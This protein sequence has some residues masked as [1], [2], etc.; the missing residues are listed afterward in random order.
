[1]DAVTTEHW[2]YLPAEIAAAISIQDITAPPKI[3]PKALVC[4]GS[5]NSVMITAES[6]GDLVLT[7]LGFPMGLLNQIF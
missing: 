3:V 2:E 5:T 1:M 4:W 7:E 6:D